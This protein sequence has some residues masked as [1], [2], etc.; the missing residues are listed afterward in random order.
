MSKWTATKIKAM[1][2][3]DKIV[4]VTA[5]D[6]TAARLVDNAGMHLVL[7]GDSLAMTMLGY[8]TTLPVT[9]EQMLHHTAAVVR[10]TEN[11]LVVADMPFMSYH[12]SREQA[13]E[14]AGRFI[15]EAGADAVKIEG[16][17]LRADAV[18]TLVANDIPVLGHI[19]L[20]PQSIR[21][22]G[23][24]KVQG[25]KP[26]DAKRLVNDAVAL[27]D[28]GVFGIVLECVPSAL[29]AEITGA[30]NVPTIGIGAGPDC[31]G[32]ILVLNDL[33]GLKGDI[34]SLPK[35]VK[36]Y[37]DMSDLVTKALATYRSEVQGGTFP[38]EEH[39]YA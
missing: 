11:A 37:A 30:V 1:K 23:G 20:T 25:K 2:G 8:T 34:I 38:A 29:G 6:Y 39:G 35:F 27:R 32:Q 24:Y 19:G 7:V 5:Y 36:Q 10:G 33:L 17:S 12:V 13:L 15:K 9:M 21:A 22:M 16:G 18:R 26:E 31:D 3:R 28:A 14:N 4:S